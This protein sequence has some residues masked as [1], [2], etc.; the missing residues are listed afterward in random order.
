MKSPLFSPE[1]KI[2]QP[3]INRWKN[4]IA[5]GLLLGSAYALIQPGGHTKLPKNTMETTV[6]SGQTAWSIASGENSK[7]ANNPGLLAQQIQQIENQIPKSQNDQ[8][9]PGETIY[10]PSGSKNAVPVPKSNHQ[11]H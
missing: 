3:Y 5:I 6:Q 7:V 2:R 8:L 10:L 1:K 4:I 9:Y 11:K